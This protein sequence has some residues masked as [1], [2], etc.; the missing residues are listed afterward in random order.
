LPSDP[1]AAAVA[2]ASVRDLAD[3]VSVPVAERL[4]LGLSELVTNALPHAVAAIRRRC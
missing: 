1:S 3:V 2:R 4:S